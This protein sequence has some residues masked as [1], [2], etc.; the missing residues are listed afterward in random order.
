[1]EVS[2]IVEKKMLEGNMYLNPAYNVKSTLL[3]LYMWRDH[4]VRIDMAEIILFLRNRG[5]QGININDS[6]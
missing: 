2:I 4:Q 5:V 1:V 6:N 3:V